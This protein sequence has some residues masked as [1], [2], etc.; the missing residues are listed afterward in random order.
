MVAT[1][2]KRKDATHSTPKYTT[3]TSSTRSR[4]RKARSGDSGAG[5]KDEPVVHMD[6]DDAVQI[7]GSELA[8]IS[9]A[10]APSVACAEGLKTANSLPSAVLEVLETATCEGFNI[11]LNCL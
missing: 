5:S 10:Q 1:P 6:T 8:A 2:R 7:S 9:S 3:R 11:R 4:G